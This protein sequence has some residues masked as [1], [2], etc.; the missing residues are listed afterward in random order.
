MCGHEIL[1]LT[2]LQ[3]IA[4]LKP[5]TLSALAAGLFKFV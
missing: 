5:L 4:S 2:F 3:K 1:A